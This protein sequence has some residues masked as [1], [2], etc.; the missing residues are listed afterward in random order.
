MWLFLKAKND[1]HRLIEHVGLK[2][3]S[4]DRS[5]LVAPEVVLRWNVDY[6]E[7][8]RHSGLKSCMR[9]PGPCKEWA[10]T[11]DAA[12]T[13]RFLSM[14][15]ICVLIF[16]KYALEKNICDGSTWVM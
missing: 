10:T 6:R 3:L 9:N 12:R 14:V 1:E 15:K 16:V 2:T 4:V 5:L 8:H 7:T 11:D 13:M